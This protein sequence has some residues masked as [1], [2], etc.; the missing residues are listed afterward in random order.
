MDKYFRANESASLVIAQKLTPLSTKTGWLG[1][2]R[3]KQMMKTRTE[4]V[5][6]TQ[7][8]VSVVSALF[9]DCRDL[10]N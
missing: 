4:D 5:V 1:K 7:H 8:L 6:T 9:S 10:I 3:G 2:G